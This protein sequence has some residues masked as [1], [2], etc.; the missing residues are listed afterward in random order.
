MQELY[1]KAFTAPRGG[2]FEFIKFHLLTH[3]PDS[4]VRYGA[5]LPLNGFHYEASLKDLVKVPYNISGKQAQVGMQ[6]VYIYI[7]F[8]L[9]LC[10]CVC[11][12]NYH[13]PLLRT[14]LLDCLLLAYDDGCFV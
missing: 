13:Q 10:V 4:I 8:L 9:C 1:K 6:L 3:Y 2:N 7:A 14:R 12:W 5:Q 11:F